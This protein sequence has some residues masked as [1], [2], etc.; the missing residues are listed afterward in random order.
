MDRKEQ[1]LTPDINT[2]AIITNAIKNI[3]DA[4]AKTA[5]EIIWDD[6]IPL[7]ATNKVI[8]YINKVQKKVEEEAANIKLDRDYHKWLNITDLN[9]DLP[10]S[11]SLPKE[12]DDPEDNWYDE[13]Y[14]DSIKLP[15]KEHRTCGT[16]SFWDVYYRHS[17]YDYI[18]REV[19]GAEEDADHFIED[20]KKGTNR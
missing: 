5:Q 1:K 13:Y 12:W 9:T 15:Y 6:D 7:D 20:L 11:Q 18:A 16:F 3:Y 19:F 4:L 8:W 14:E 17:E 10:D 2:P